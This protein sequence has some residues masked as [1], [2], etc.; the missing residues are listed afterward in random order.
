MK[1]ILA[2]WTPAILALFE[3]SLVS[4][5]S[6]LLFASC[7]PRGHVWRRSIVGCN[8]ADLPFAQMEE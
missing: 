5:V 4:E 3:D 7:S 6:L 2:P 1:E 8:S